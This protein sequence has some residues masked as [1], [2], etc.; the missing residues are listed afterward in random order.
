MIE[1]GK[2]DFI[3]QGRLAMDVFENNRSLFGVDMVQICKKR[4]EIVSGL[5]ERCVTLFESNSIDVIRPTSFFEA[6]GIEYAFRLMQKGQNIGKIVVR[7]PLDLTLLKVGAKLC[8][9]RFR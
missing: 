6:S 2:R 8:D 9:L 3:G 4:P 5:L 1:L 7:M